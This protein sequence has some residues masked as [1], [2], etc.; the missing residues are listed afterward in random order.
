MGK[1]GPEKSILS[2]KLFCSSK[3]KIFV[4]KNLD[5]STLH[6]LESTSKKWWKNIFMM[7]QKKV[8]KKRT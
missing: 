6:Y 1:I 2:M 4:H 8:W 7:G 5:L 3:I